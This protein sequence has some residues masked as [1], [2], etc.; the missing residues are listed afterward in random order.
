MTTFSARTFD[1]DE[2]DH[3]LEQQ[4]PDSNHSNQRKAAGIVPYNDAKTDE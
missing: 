4:K 1:E 2:I 3:C